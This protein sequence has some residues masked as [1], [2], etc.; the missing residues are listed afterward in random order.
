MI[1]NALLKH[2][3]QIDP[4]FQEDI[5]ALF[6]GQKHG[7]ME[8]WEYATPLYKGDPAGGIAYWT[9]LIKNPGNYYLIQA[10]VTNVQQ[11]LRNRRFVETLKKIEHVI[12]LGPGCEKSLLQKT[13]RII[14]SAPALKSYQVID[15]TYDV[16]R[17]AAD[18]VAKHSGLDPIA[19]AQDYIQSPFI[20]ARQG[21]AALVIWGGSIGN[22]SGAM[23]ESV[24]SKLVKQLHNFQQGLDNDDLVI[25]SFDA[26]QD[27][28]KVKNAYKEESLKKD[29]L[30]VLFR[31]KREGILSSGFNP[32]MW[33]SEP[34]W[35]EKTSQCCHTIYPVIDQEF[36]VGGEQVFVPQG[37]RFVSNNS[38]KYSPET[39][40]S[41][42][43]MAGFSSAEIFKFGS[44]GMLVAHKGK[45]P[46]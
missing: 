10:D 30:S 6:L 11:S 38:Y 39:M 26:E 31:A 45:N 4:D 32:Y 35:V 27:A 8:K 29:I 33:E 9:E 2:S 15:S 19:Q 16:S 34:I 24:F 1:L 7:H 36:K 23:G 13:L 20:K 44:M 22:F 14:K 21:R 43:S 42:A 17:K 40:M 3:P 25:I 46:A 37:K 18:F 41:A 12:E 28:G 5:V